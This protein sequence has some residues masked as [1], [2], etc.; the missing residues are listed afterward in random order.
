MQPKRCHLQVVL[1]WDA[2]VKA[3]VPGEIPLEVLPAT[4]QVSR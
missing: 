3:K 2:R 1:D 4:Q